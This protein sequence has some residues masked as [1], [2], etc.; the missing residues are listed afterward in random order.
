MRAAVCRAFNQELTIEDLDLAAMGPRDVQI[1]ID[2]CA[3]CHSDI[4][5]IE[6]AWGGDLPAVAG[7]EATGKVMAVGAEVTDIQPGNKVIVTLIHSCG[8]CAHCLDGGMVYCNKPNARGS[9]PRLR[10]PNGETILQWASTG[11]FA[12]QVVVDRS[13]IVRFDHNIASASVAL[14]AC[15]VITGLGAVVNSAKVPAGAS[16][17]VIG[18]G[19]VGLNAIQGAV[20]SEAS[21][22]IAID[23]SPQKLEIAEQFG[24][25]H[26]I[27]PSTKDAAS[28][29]Q[30]ICDGEGAHFVFVAVGAKAAIDGAF[31][32]L[33]RGGTLVVVGMPAGGVLGEFDAAG[34]AA[35]GLRVIGSRMGESDIQRDIPMLLD[36]YAN[37]RL[38]L[39]EL[40]S[41]TYGLS[42][43]NEAIASVNRGEALR[44]VLVF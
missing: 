24:A 17:V 6:G 44:H 16:V 21:R 37:G 2:A 25:T 14:L 43:I 19:G 31:S 39:D 42:D 34:L 33:R 41:G 32:M 7:H 13:Q 12:E 40:V 20:L 38:K 23:L 8:T 10:S 30:S 9:K 35:D 15:G 18:C 4:H 26:A 22:V 27:N 3:I 36:H 5:F 11:A 1:A 29:V 28:M